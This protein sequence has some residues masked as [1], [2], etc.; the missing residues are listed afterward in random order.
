MEKKF[1][2]F[3]QFHTLLAVFVLVSSFI[4]LGENETAFNA[5]AAVVSVL[6][7]TGFISFFLK[8]TYAHKILFAWLLLQ[9]IIIKPYYF[10]NQFPS[11]NFMGNVFGLQVGI[12]VIPLLLFAFAKGIDAFA[13]KR[14]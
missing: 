11:I 13:K 5:L 3:I 6:G 4:K 8:H 12:N 1:S 10:V 2:Y 9:V 7:I 14:L